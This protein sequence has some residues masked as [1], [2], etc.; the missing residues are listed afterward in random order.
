[1]STIFPLRPHTPPPPISR[2][3]PPYFPQPIYSKQLTQIKP[4]KE[5]VKT[6]PKTVKKG[7]ETV[8]IRPK[9]VKKAPQLV[10]NSPQAV[11]GAAD[12]GGRQGEAQ[13]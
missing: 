13:L 5:T 6:G 3:S 9:N 4:R 10:T 8:K 1:L 11:E 7:H 2:S 12:R